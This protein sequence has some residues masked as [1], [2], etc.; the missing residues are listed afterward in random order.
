MADDVFCPRCHSEQ[1]AVANANNG[2][3]RCAFCR[4]LWIDERFIHKTETLKFLEEQ[5]KQ[6]R[7]V[8]DNSTETDRQM[9]SAFSRLLGLGSSPGGFLRGCLNTFT[10][11]IIA[12]VVAVLFLALMLFVCIA[13]LNG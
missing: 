4:N 7:I 2:L 10:R 12:L 8:M 13:V 9:I 5:A 3:L 1:F 6:P 11:T